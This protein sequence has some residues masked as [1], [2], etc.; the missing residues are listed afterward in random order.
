LIRCLIF[1]DL[2]AGQMCQS[3]QD[4]KAPVVNTSQVYDIFLGPD[5]VDRQPALMAPVLRGEVFS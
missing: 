3:G 5:R 2:P 4:S 1:P